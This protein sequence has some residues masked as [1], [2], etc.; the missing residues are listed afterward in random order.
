MIGNPSNVSRLLLGLAIV[1][2]L[3]SAGLSQS[4]SDDAIQFAF[5]HETFEF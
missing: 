2:L 5:H 1:L 3:P 4:L